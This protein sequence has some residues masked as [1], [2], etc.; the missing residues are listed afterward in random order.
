MILVCYVFCTVLIL[1]LF[2]L[3]LLPFPKKIILR[4]G[5]PK[6][7]VLVAARNEEHNI[8]D[9]VLSLL[10]QN[11]PTDKIQLIVGDDNSS[12]GTLTILN[13]LSKEHPSLEVYS[14]FKK[15]KGLNGKANVLAQIDTHATGEILLFT[16]ADTEANP[17]W[18]KTLVSSFEEGIGIVTGM[19][20][21][22]DKLS[23]FQGIDWVYALIQVI[24][25]S[26]LGIPTTSMGNNM[27]VLA[28]A[29][30]RVG[31]YAA[32]AHTLTEDF[33]LFHKIIGLKYGYR[34]VFQEESVL[35]TKPIEGLL[36]L[37]YQRKRWM[38]GAVKLPFIIIFILLL[39]AAFYP[40]IVYLL[41]NSLQV[42]MLIWGIKISIQALL[43]ALA[44][45]RLNL[46]VNGIKLIFYEFY[47]LLLTSGVLLFYILPIK[48]KWKGRTYS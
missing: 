29:Y 10:N 6:V 48:V 27:G 19:T 22:E 4:D 14:D 17:N 40:I 3:L 45:R 12:D 11:Y 5:T 39:L 28:K 46:R 42:V 23:L 36:T 21:P 2:F 33:S 24:K 43:I 15:L 20:V 44:F 26:A 13:D 38:T 18:V 8:R 25:I 32:I 9:C 47:S 34:F 30:H 35:K 1:A 37:L 7:S 16:D 41:F 31:G